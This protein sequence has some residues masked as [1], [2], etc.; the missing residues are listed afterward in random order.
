[1][2]TAD[3]SPAHGPWNPGIQSQIP[4]E[5][6][7]LSTIFRPEN[8]FTSIAAVSEMHGLTGFSPS[9]LVAFRPQRLALHELLIRVTAD[10]AVPDGTRIGDLG[11]NFREI[12]SLLFERYLLPEMDAIAAVYERARRELRDAMD[13][14]LAGVMP[15][16]SPLDSA[17]KRPASRLF[18]RIARRRRAAPIPVDRGW[19]PRHIADCERLA[20]LRVDPQQK[21][22]YRTLARVM[23]ALFATQGH[24]WGTRELI[25]SVATNMA[26][27]EYGSD[28]IGRTIE[29][30][31]LR[32]SRSEGYP[33]LPRQE[34]PVVINTK[35]PSASGKST[36]RPLQKKLA[37]DIGVRWSDFALISP[38]IW[39]KQLLDYGV[40][41][42]AYKYAGAFTAEELQIVDQKLDRYM[43]RKHLRGDM[44]HLLIDRFRFDS[45]A[46]D[47]DEAGSNLLTR[48]GQTVYLFFVIT[49][50]E[51]LVERAWKRGLEFGRYKAV[52]DTLAHAVEAYTGIPDVFFTWVR[53]SDKRIQFEF[54]DNTVR[55]G[56][57]PRTVAFGD[58]D[59]FNVLDVKGMLDIERYGRVNIDAAAPES[60]Y[61][62]R[63]LLD[64]AHN[65]GFLRRC[66]DGFPVVNFADRATGRIFLRI[67]SRTPVWM[68]GILMQS[69]ISDPDTLSG[70]RAVAPSVLS[71][72]V[73]EA[74]APQ[75]LQGQPGARAAPTLGQ[76]GA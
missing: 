24:A 65:T 8:V 53:R 61:A 16:H 18:A 54:L 70:I 37:G 59:T 15:E 35:G 46:P 30:M 7:H 33:L 28:S 66:M 2:N 55:L 13:A 22:V 4:R 57:R 69:A 31:L 36:L 56:E 27:N 14:A 76:W 38:D 25:A 5:L 23:S 71:G 43:S 40:L 1:M 9:E 72:G 34:R 58:N 41:G 48:F 12:A 11:I 68:D 75:S 50:P 6:L 62:D 44:T 10:F 74:E 60:L 3:G 49:P 64:P 67:E 63:R 32:A 39:R 45:F 42:S 47:S 52:D 21:I 51:L 19:G 26:C 17:T 73:P 29:P 20:G